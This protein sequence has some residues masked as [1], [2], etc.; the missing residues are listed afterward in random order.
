MRISWLIITGIHFLWILILLRNRNSDHPWLLPIFG[1]ATLLDILMFLL[2]TPSVGGLDILNSF[3]NS[4]YGWVIW[5]SLI[6][7]LWLSWFSLFFLSCVKLCFGKIKRLWLVTI[8]LSLVIVLFVTFSVSG[9]LDRYWF[10]IA[11]HCILEPLILVVS[12]SLLICHSINVIKRGESVDV[13]SLYL[14]LSL[15][16][17]ALR[18]LITI[19]PDYT[20]IRDVSH[21]LHYVTF[22]VFAVSYSLDKWISQSWVAR[23]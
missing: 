21:L 17:L 4:S 18:V 7:S 20:T 1:L 9:I 16:C 14:R 23:L 3:R 6:H 11:S 2:S 13:F 19:R 22:I 8:I 12:Y 10:R 15:L 5:Y